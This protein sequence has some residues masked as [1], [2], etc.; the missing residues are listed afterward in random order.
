MITMV[1]EGPIGWAYLV[2]ADDAPV[3]FYVTAPQ[4]I[5]LTARDLDGR[6]LTATRHRALRSSEINALRAIREH[7]FERLRSSSLYSAHD[8]TA[9]RALR[10]RIPT[11]R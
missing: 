11:T 8:H 7:T 1:E 5:E 9:G 2:I 3:D 4:V 6:T 10:E